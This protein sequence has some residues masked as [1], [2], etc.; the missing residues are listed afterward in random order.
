M[1][2]ALWMMRGADETAAAPRTWWCSLTYGDRTGPT[3]RYCQVP[4]YEDVK[5]FIRTIRKVDPNARYLVTFEHGGKKGRPHW[6]VLLHV[7]DDVKRRTC[8]AAWTHGFNKCVLAKGRGLG[9]Y[10][11]K[12][13]AKDGR[14]RASIGYGRI[15]RQ[16]SPEGVLEMN[17]YRWM[18]DSPFDAKYRAI[19]HQMIAT[20]LADA[21]K[22]RALLAAPSEED[23]E[24]ELTEAGLLQMHT[25]LWRHVDAPAYGETKK[26]L[27]KAIKRIEQ[28]ARQPIAEV[29]KQIQ[30]AHTKVMTT[31]GHESPPFP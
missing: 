15:L 23:E 6:H 1:R 24:T 30:L 5:R 18:S 11:A 21:R 27:L 25:N 19:K 13:A 12:Y 28:E 8:N 7:T 3:G 2:R 26:R 9:S 31:E 4:D 29:V 10:I 17:W 16:F 20:M 14:L 22:R